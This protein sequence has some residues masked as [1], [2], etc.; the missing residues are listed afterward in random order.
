MHGEIVQINISPGGLPKTP[1][2]EAVV[3]PLGIVGDD[4]RDKRYHGGPLQALLLIAAEVVDQLREDGWPIFYG[5]LGENLTTRGLDWKQWRPGQIF[6]AGTVLL[7]LTKPRQPCLNLDRYGEGLEEYI[8]DWRG[9]RLDFSS[10]YW[11]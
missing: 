4:Q 11:V 3:Q 9:K 6:R 8:Y 2:S 5:A 7:Q 10:S 1:I